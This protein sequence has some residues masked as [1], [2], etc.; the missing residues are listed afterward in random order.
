MSVAAAH[1]HTN[2]YTSAYSSYSELRNGHSLHVD[3]T[4]V[5]VPGEAIE[6]QPPK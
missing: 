6:V 2:P 5:N 3:S 1:T 4:D